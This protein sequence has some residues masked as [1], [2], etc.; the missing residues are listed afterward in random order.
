[1][2]R[3]RWRV[4]WLLGLL[5]LAAAA[6]FVLADDSGDSVEWVKVGRGDLVIGVE[7]TGKLRSVDT[8]SLGP[9]QL[10]EYWEFKI[11]HI[12]PEGQEVEA[13]TPVLSFDTSDLR[14][15]LL[16]QQAEADQA[17]KQIEKTEKTLA[18]E[19]RQSLLQL[20]EAEARL[21]KAQLIV[22][23]PEELSK[24]K[25]LTMARLDH[26]L[27]TQEV[28]HLR[29][30]LEASDRSASAQLATLRAQLERAEQSVKQL[31][32]AME[33]M[34]RKSPRAGTVIYV[35][36]WNDN[37]KKVGDSCWKQ[38]YVIEVPDL[39][40]MKAEGEVDEADAGLLADGQTVSIRLDAHPDVEFKGSVSSI[41]RT[42]QR[43]SWRNPLKVAK[44][45]IDL[46]ETDTERMRPGMRFRGEVVAERIADTLLL[47][48]DSVRADG[49]KPRVARRT[50]TGVDWIPVELGR[51]NDRFVEVLSGVKE[52]DEV[53]LSAR[54]V[55]AS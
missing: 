5:A 17:R 34:V 47:P 6:Y 29:H 53:A 25:E 55:A 42:V 32:E 43:K 35:T 39:S 18:L 38:E 27:S 50:F 51:R 1:M 52:G 15:R 44:L 23:V 28:G 31:T 54:A 49:G 45:E 40:R 24:A 30:R 22:D 11:A 20:E 48:V 16:Q 2:S 13:G 46:D 9:P 21:R 4:S 26:E 19:R 14:Q 33:Q 8:S 7:V 12:A 36:D 37:K 41:W 10:R 3:R